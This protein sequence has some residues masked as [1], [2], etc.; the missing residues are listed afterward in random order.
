MIN[1]L[2]SFN[3]IGSAKITTDVR[4]RHSPW[5]CCKRVMKVQERKAGSKERGGPI[6]HT[7]C[8]KCDNMERLVYIASR[9][10]K[11]D[12][13]CLVK[14]IRKKRKKECSDWDSNPDLRL[15]LC[16]CQ[17]RGVI[18]LT[19]AWRV[20]SDAMRGGSFRTRC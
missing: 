14:K 13:K 5:C 11:L 8:R 3:K 7:A 20:L 12:G 2:V 19:P 1:A 16:S 4:I 18:L 15:S 6:A 9:Y 17:L 10:G